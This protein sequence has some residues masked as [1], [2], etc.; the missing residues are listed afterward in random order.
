[1]Y[2]CVCVCVG[3]HFYIIVL[4]FLY[5]T[6]FGVQHFVRPFVKCCISKDFFDL[7][8]RLANVPSRFNKKGKAVLTICIIKDAPQGM[9]LR[10]FVHFYLSTLPY[11]SCLFGQHNTLSSCLTQFATHVLLKLVMF[12]SKMPFAL[13]PLNLAHKAPTFRSI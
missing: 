11:S 7:Y 3:F 1:M 12:L 5:T 9:V 13:E 4:S 8:W 6:Y 2:V 10:S